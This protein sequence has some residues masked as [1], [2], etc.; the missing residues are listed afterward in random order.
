MI[1]D[2]VTSSTSVTVAISDDQEATEI[3]EGM[4]I[5]K[6]LLGL[7]SL[8]E[9]HAGDATPEVLVVPKPPMPAPPPTI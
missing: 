5:E 9:S 4:M 8:L 2:A 3:P 6:R 7:L 1:K